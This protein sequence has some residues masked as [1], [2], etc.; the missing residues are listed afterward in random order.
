MLFLYILRRTAWYTFRY[1]SCRCAGSTQ[2]SVAFEL[3]GLA[4]QLRAGNM[5]SGYW[6]AAD[7]AYVPM[8]GWLTPWSRSALSAENGIF[9]E[10]FNFYHSSHRVH[11]EQAFGILINRWGRLWRPI[12]YH[13]AY[14]LP[15]LSAAMKLHNYSIEEERHREF[16]NMHTEHERERVAEAFRIW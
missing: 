12:K 2:D 6:I 10:A 16:F 13:L 3:S 7:A 9:A 11:V 15:F 1:I 4:H 5:L 8:P 14:S